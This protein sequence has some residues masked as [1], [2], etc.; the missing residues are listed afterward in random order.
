MKSVKRVLSL[1]LTF[2]LISLSALPA[3]AAKEQLTFLIVSGSRNNS[4]LVKTVTLA[5]AE[6][7][8]AGFSVAVVSDTSVPV[9]GAVLIKQTEGLGEE[10][11]VIETDGNINLYYSEEGYSSYYGGA[12]FNGLLYGLRSILKMKLSGGVTDERFSPDT[13]ERTVMLD[14]ARKFYTIDWIKNFIRQMSWMGYNSLELHMTEEQGARCNIWRD[15]AGNSVPDCNGNDFSFMIGYSDVSW[16]TDYRDPAA[17]YFYNRNELAD[18]VSWAKEY[19]IEIIPSVDFPGHSYNLINRFE[20]M[21]SS[22]EFSF[23]YDGYTFSGTAPISASGSN[24]ACID[25]SSQFARAL[26]FAITD[27]Y[28]AFFRRF[29]CSKFNIGGDEVSVNDE[30]WVTYASERGGYSQGDAFIIYMNSLAD[31]V[32]AR[33]Y[34]ARAFNDYFDSVS[35]SVSVSPSLEMVCWSTP[36]GTY[37]GRTMYN[38][39]VGYTYYV[40]RNNSSAG[41]ARSETN[42]HWWFNHAS[43]ERIYSGCGGCGYGGCQVSGG[44][45]PTLFRNYN[46][47]YGPTVTGSQLGGG[48]F[49]IWGDWAGWDTE[50][51]MWM[52]N[53]GYNLIDRMWANI[54]KMLDSDA[55]SS[56]S[57][58]AYS[59]KVSA[60]RFFPGFSSPSVASTVA[61]GYAQAMRSDYASRTFLEWDADSDGSVTVADARLIMRAAENPET[62][63]IV[64]ACCDPDGNGRIS[65]S[66][67]E[68]AFATAVGLVLPVLNT[69]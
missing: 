44:W 53:D 18:I 39:L 29:G 13:K 52:R 21:Y 24:G 37:G 15:A 66:D 38:A 7:I 55:D 59:A 45:N 50:E 61:V 9:S 62:T 36:P 32:K 25:V 4:A 69:R 26:S 20:N 17:A 28:A 16:N 3:V 54:A 23:N 64:L 40:L 2:L 19:H 5:A 63:N 46:S 56:L 65:A 14:I 1:F 41:D 31:I 6:F 42:T 57:F 58:G 33:G 47:S 8:D 22:S 12:S 27:A 67:A 34:R 35:A 10:G 43:A 11:Y 60:Y 48:Y 49:L 30:N 51:N 68:K